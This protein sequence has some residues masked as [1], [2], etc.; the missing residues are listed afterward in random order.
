MSLLVQTVSPCVI[1]GADSV[2]QCHCWC[3]LSL[4]VIV[5]TDSVTQCHCWCRQCH[6]VSL[7]VQTVSLCVIVGADSVTRCHCW[8]RQCHSV[9]LLVQIVSLNVIVGADS[10]TQCTV[11]QFGVWIHSMNN[12][13]NVYFN[14]HGLAYDCSPVNGSVCGT[15]VVHE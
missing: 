8:C 5:G 4:S 1:V 9:S 13:N 6:S 3:R 14:I 11:I 12:V 2:T 10:V 7:L 15:L